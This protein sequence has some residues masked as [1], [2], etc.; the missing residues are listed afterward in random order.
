MGTKAALLEAIRQG[1]GAALCLAGV[2][3]AVD[4]SSLNKVVGSVLVVIDGSGVDLSSGLRRSLIN[5]RG[6][7]FLTGRR[8]SFSS[9]DFATELVLLTARRSSLA[10]YT[11]YQQN[12]TTP[13][14]WLSQ[15]MVS[16]V[17]HTVII[18]TLDILA[19]ELVHLALAIVRAVRTVVA[20]DNAIFHDIPEVPRAVSLFIVVCACE[21]GEADD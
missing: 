3:V 18:V 6:R 1:S 19:Y 10:R 13:I 8:S 17:S 11:L 7:S 15:G 14:P 20:R 2:V 4:I 5:G 21:S 12:I 9:T 16:A